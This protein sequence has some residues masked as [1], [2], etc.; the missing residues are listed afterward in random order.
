M[1]A[2]M[3]RN[4]YTEYFFI[5]SRKIGNKRWQRHVPGCHRRETAERHVREIKWRNLNSEQPSR[6]Y[7]ILDEFDFPA[8]PG[9]IAELDRL[10]SADGGLE[11][12]QKA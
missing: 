9:R 5:Y 10:S 12:S 1:S 7:V 3:H 8:G 2:V 11:K 4:P 6:E